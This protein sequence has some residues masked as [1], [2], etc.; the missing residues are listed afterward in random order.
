M[1]VLLILDGEPTLEQE[2]RGHNFQCFSNDLFTR[3]KSAKLYP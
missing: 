1:K 3:N 2:G